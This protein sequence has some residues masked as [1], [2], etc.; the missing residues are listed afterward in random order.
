MERRVNDLIGRMRSEEK[1]ALI[2]HR[3]NERLG[4]PALE[5]VYGVM[6]VSAK[7]A[8]TAFPANIG[9]AASWDPGLAEQEG[10]VIAQQARAL[11][12]GEVLGPLTD[13]SH[14][15]LSGRVFETYGEDPWVT[16]RMVI[17][18]VSGVQGEG[19]IATAIFQDGSAGQRSARESE[20]RP[21]EAAVTEAGVW[22][23]M[24]RDGGASG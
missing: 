4:I 17:G 8:A 5:A 18:Y 14:S 12:R 13:V 7:V 21:L 16:S 6:G 9:M 24:P 1:L 10:V 23:V 11:G 20:L 19:A 22:A 2:A 15:P 3:G